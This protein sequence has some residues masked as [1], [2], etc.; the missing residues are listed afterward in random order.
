LEKKAPTPPESDAR[1]PEYYR[2]RPCADMVA[3]AAEITE[4]YLESNPE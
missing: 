1:T 3:L 4:K 2:K